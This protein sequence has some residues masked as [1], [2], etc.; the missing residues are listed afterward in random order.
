MT[1]LELFA[2]CL[3]IATKQPVKEIEQRLREYVDHVEPN[4]MMYEEAPGAVVKRLLNAAEKDPL[5]VMTSGLK[6]LDGFLDVIKS[7]PKH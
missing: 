1:Y 4:A 3:A 5:G 7:K 2:K 6:G